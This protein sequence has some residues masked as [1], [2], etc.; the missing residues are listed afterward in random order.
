MI[1]LCWGTLE[2]DMTGSSSIHNEQSQSRIVLSIAGYTVAV[3]CNDDALAAHLRQHYARFSPA[4]SEPPLLVLSATLDPHFWPVRMQAHETAYCHTTRCLETPGSEG[5]IDI[6]AG[7][8]RQRLSPRHPATDIEYALRVIYALLAVRAGGLLF[9]GAGIVRCGQT[10]LFFGHSGSGKTTVSRLSPDDTVLND[11]L[12][13]LLPGEHTWTAYATPFWNPTQAGQ[14]MPGSAP[15]GVLLR[16]V[17]APHVGLEP[18]SQGQAL[19]EVLSC[20]PG[21]ASDATSSLRLLAIGARL[22]QM[23]PIWRLHFLP[24]ASFWTVVEPLAAPQAHT[25]PSEQ[26]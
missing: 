18:L 7:Y 17:Q 11:D 12:V 13:L 19:A 21:L 1:K 26:R 2:Q 23:V 14:P 15:L 4:G 25:M 22:L 16:L 3:A 9:H 20:V 10:F 5:M 24:D 6:D 8:A